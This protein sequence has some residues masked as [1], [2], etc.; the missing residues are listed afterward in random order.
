AQRG[1]W[2]L[3]LACGLLFAMLFTTLL[4]ASS[5]SP[6]CSRGTVLYSGDP[7][8]VA[9][10]C[11]AGSMGSRHFGWVPW[12]SWKPTLVVGGGGEMIATHPD[13]TRV[14]LGGGRLRRRGMASSTGCLLPRPGVASGRG[15][16]VCA[17]V[18]GTSGSPDGDLYVADSFGWTVW[19]LGEE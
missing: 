6:S 10:D 2:R 9:G 4:L 16:T 17:V 5:P 13:G 18:A 19:S 8:L 7:A 11:I 12:V 15:S 3:L 1:V 14:T